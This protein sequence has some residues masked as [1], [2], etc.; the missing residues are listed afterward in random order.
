MQTPNPAL[1][2]CPALFDVTTVAK[3]PPDGR[4]E[5]VALDALELAP[6]ARREISREAIER[7]AGMLRRP[8]W[9]ASKLKRA[10]AQ[11]PL[12][13]RDRTGEPLPVCEEADRV[14]AVTA[15]DREAWG[16]RREKI[17]RS[18]MGFKQS[19]LAPVAD[20]VCGHSEEDEESLFRY[21]SSSFLTEFFR[22][23]D[24]DYEHDGSTR[25]HWV[26]EVLRLILAEPQPAANVP[27]GTFRRGA[28]V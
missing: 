1:L 11:R 10:V 19:T 2:P 24:T 22:D 13:P 15:V 6:N 20:M 9:G 27:P 17:S 23:C 25:N 26:A 14:F 21:R 12:I 28:G 7:L 18:P 4:I 16:H 5:R 8:G 3:S